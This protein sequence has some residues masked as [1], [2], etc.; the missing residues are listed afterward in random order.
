MNI[1]YVQ[2]PQVA[3]PKLNKRLK[4]HT[5][6]MVLSRGR[7]VEAGWPYTETV[8]PGSFDAHGSHPRIKLVCFV[9]CAGRMEISESLAAWRRA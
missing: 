9:A 7:K 3:M 1:N 5:A 2:D 6:R 8:G 4:K